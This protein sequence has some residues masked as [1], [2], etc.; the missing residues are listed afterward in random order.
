ML[1]PDN[2]QPELSI[3]Y[4]ASL[5]IDELQKNNNQDIL[6]LFDNVKTKNNMSFSIFILCLDFLYLI[7]VAHIDNKGNI[8]LCS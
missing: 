1:L 5:V 6:I 2:I 7:D 3:Y 8:S 4:N